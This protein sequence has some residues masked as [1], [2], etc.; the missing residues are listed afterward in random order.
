MSKRDLWLVG[1]GMSIMGAIT[2]V[3]SHSLFL[4][5]WNM[6]WVGIDLYVIGNLEE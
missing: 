5:V 6:V 3:L 2:G 1:L 4:V